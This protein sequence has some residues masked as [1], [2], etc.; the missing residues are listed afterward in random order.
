[1][2][3]KADFKDSDP[4]P[5]EHLRGNEDYFYGI[6]HGDDQSEDMRKDP[7]KV[8]G[9]FW[10][11]DAMFTLQMHGQLPNSYCQY[12]KVALYTSF[13]KMHGQYQWRLPLILV[14]NVVHGWLV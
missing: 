3:V 11:E 12:W 8:A 1:M 4:K 7:T 13:N 14:F 9:W 2:F 6:S 10:T 5:L